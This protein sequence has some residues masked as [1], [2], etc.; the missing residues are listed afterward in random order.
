MP[1]RLAALPALGLALAV[2]LAVGHRARV[3]DDV[4]DAIVFA[5]AVLA[6]LGALTVLAPER[7][8]PRARLAIGAMCAVTVALALTTP[9]G[10]PGLS[11]AVDVALVGL[12]HVAGSTIGRRV[13]TPGHLLPAAVVAA[14]ADLVS[15]LHPAGPTRAIVESERAM[16]ALAFSF[17]VPGALDLAPALGLGDLVFV[18]LA[19]GVAV[20]HGLSVRR[21]SLAATAG[22]IAAGGL[23]MALQRPV[24]ALPA[25]G[26]LVVLSDPRARAL[27]GRDR[28]TAAAAIVLAIAA[29]A[30][31]L[32][33]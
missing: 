12:A 22:A 28:R 11:I 14:C 1:R 6:S 24:P 21:T 8:P 13:Q 29:A 32:L 25:I 18:A 9:G 30:G 10:H 4:A 31:A 19:L 3:P 33:R 15:A 7:S 27:T 16:N 5:G 26:A 23:S 20:T 2:A 17:P